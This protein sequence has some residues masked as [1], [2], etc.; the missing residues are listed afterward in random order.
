MSTKWY[1]PYKIN[2][3]MIKIKLKCYTL[4]NVVV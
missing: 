2:D 3:D 4:I 1:L